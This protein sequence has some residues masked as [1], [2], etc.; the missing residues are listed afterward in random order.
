MNLRNLILSIRNDKLKIFLI[1]YFSPRIIF[2]LYNRIICAVWL[3]KINKYAR[4]KQTN[5][6]LVSIPRGYAA[7]QTNL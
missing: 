1:K 7:G 3:I 6:R 5:N 4:I 2:L